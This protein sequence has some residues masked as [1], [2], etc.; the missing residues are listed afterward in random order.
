MQRKAGFAQGLSLLLPVTLSVMGALLIAPVIP[1]LFAAFHNV[2]GIMFLAPM[3]VTTPSL[4]VFL[5]SPVAG[6][7]GDRFGRRPLLIAA[8]AIYTIFGVAP[9]FLDNLFAV[10]ATRV[11]VGIMEAIVL[12]LSTTLISDLFTDGERDRWLAAQTGVASVSAVV[13]LLIGGMAGRFGWHGP[14]LV[15]ILPLVLMFG[16]IVFTWEPKPDRAGV[17]LPRLSLSW[18]GFPWVF[19]LGICALTL[20]A[21]TMFYTVQ[22][23]LS[24]ALVALGVTDPA[25]IG[26]LTAIASLAVP[27]GSVAFWMLAPRLS[28]RGMLLVEFVLLGVGFVGMSHMADPRGFVVAA[29]LNQIGAGMILPTLLTWVTQGLSFEIRARGT[30]FWQSTFALGQFACGLIVP[31]IAR[32][33]GGV[34]PAFQVIGGASILGALVVVSTMMFVRGN[35]VAAEREGL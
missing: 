20:F 9:F 1:Q 5:F 3:V 27:F 10:L 30:G 24:T 18:A 11:V 35:G 8:M 7:L 25:R 34:V 14:F 17:I 19:V 16:V 21:S 31:A 22:I 6:L 33:V 2:P 32:V 26:L 29:A 13:F 4:F 28:V 15:Y 23:Q 12:T